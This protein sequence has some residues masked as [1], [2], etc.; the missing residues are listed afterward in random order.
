MAR[1]AWFWHVA[2]HICKVLIEFVTKGK[3]QFEICEIQIE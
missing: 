1:R 3:A 2:S